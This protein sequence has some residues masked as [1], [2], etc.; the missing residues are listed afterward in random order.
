M[1]TKIAPDTV[2]AQYG[3]WESCS[4]LD[5]P[6]YDLDRFNY[7]RLIDDENVDP[8]SGSNAMRGYPCSITRGIVT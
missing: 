7:N 5:L 8:A 2:C 6:G 4:G 3:W 1:T